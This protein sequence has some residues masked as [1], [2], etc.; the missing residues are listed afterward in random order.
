MKQTGKRSKIQPA[1]PRKNRWTSVAIGLG[2]L[3]V[4]MVGWIAFSS[5]QNRK[6]AIEETGSPALRVDKE[7]VD[8]GEVSYGQD[9]MVSFDLTNIGDKPLAFAEPPY[10]EVKE[11]C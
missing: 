1:D 10:I 9:V 8:L 3:M 5:A 4:I 6:A 7:K 2:L 11:G